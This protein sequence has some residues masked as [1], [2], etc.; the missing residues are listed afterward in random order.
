MRDSA[1]IIGTIA[2]LS[3]VSGLFG[4][5]ASLWVATV[6][7]AYCIGVFWGACDQMRKQREKDGE[8]I[9]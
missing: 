4:H 6:L 2:A 1:I 5:M 7:L 8:M 3:I 9:P